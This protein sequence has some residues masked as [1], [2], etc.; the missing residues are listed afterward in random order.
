[1]PEFSLKISSPEEMA[2]LAAA[3]EKA[4]PG[5]SV[6]TLRGELGSGKTVFARGFARACGVTEP[7]TSP[8]FTVL[9]EYRL[10]SGG[11]LY[12]F[13]LYRIGG[14]DAALAFGV[15][16]YLNAPCRAVLIEWPGAVAGMLPPGAASVSFEHIDENSRKVT[17]AA[18]AGEL[19]AIKETLAGSAVPVCS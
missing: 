1:M 3:M 11:T 16:E 17:V 15:D 8:T 14:P 7:V 19:D 6:V 10:P 12:H 18:A 9:Q 13:D 4:L 2:L 5:N